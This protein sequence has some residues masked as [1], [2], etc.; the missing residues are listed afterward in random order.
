MS[1]YYIC[2]SVIGAASIELSTDDADFME[3]YLKRGDVENKVEDTPV[4]YTDIYT[5]KEQ[6]E[7]WFKSEVEKGLLSLLS[8][9]T[10]DELIREYKEKY[11]F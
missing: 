10:L 6:Y 5:N 9:K 1:K 3:W 7:E 4:D 8:T 2:N 11:K